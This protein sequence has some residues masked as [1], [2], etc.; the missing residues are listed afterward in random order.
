ML[1]PMFFAGAGYG[2]LATKRMDM[3]QK[4]PGLETLKVAGWTVPVQIIR[5]FA[6]NIQKPVLESGIAL[7]YG[8]FGGP[9]TSLY[10]MCLGRQ[11]AIMAATF[12]YAYKNPPSLNSQRETMV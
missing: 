10:A 2:A 11:T 7:A 9:V 3:Y 4:D 5:I 1:F 8:I 12:Y 6:Q